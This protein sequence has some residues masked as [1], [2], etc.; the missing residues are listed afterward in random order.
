MTD[1]AE[2]YR[3]LEYIDA[4]V[5]AVEP[6]GTVF[7]SPF[8]ANT[9][10]RFSD[11]ELRVLL[12]DNDA[13]ASLGFSASVSEYDGAMLYTLSEQYE[14]TPGMTVIPTESI[15]RN[16]RQRETL[17]N[18]S[19]VCAYSDGTMDGVYYALSE[20]AHLLDAD[21]AALFV[22][23][24]ASGMWKSDCF[25]TSDGENSGYNVRFEIPTADFVPVERRLD[26]KSAS[27]LTGLPEASV[28]SGEDV[29]ACAAKV[30]T[31]NGSRAIL[32]LEKRGVN[33]AW[34]RG[35]VSFIY[36]IVGLLKMA[37]RRSRM[38]RELKCA[39]DDANAAS[40]AK[41]EFISR[42]S[43]EIRTPMNA[44]LGMIRLA[45]DSCS[46]DGDSPEYIRDCLRKAEGAGV[47]LLGIINDVLDF[48]LIE[49]GKMTLN[50]RSFMLSELLDRVHD[51]ITFAAADKDI[52]LSCECG[53]DVPACLYGDTQR[54]AQIMI[55]L[56]NNAV[57]FTESG[58]VR[59]RVSRRGD[60]LVIAVSD[61][62]SGIR[63]EDIGRLFRSFE[64]VNEES[65]RKIEGTGLGL[66]ITKEIIGHMGGEISVESVFGE[67]S[68]FTV[69][70]PLE[71]GR[72][73]E[74][75]AE[76]TDSDFYSP[77]SRLLVA[78]DNEVNLAVTVAV[79][80]KFGIDADT[81]SDGREA[82]RKAAEREYDLILMDH[83]MPVM[84]GD[85][86]CA[87]I[88]S[89]GPNAETPILALTANTALSVRRQL[90][91]SGMNDVV[92]KPFTPNQLSSVLEKYLSRQQAEIKEEQPDAPETASIPGV[93]VEE[94]AERMGCGMEFYR[95]ALRLTAAAIPDSIAAQR[96]QLSSGEL[97]ALRVEA[98]GIKGALNTIGAYQAAQ[99]ALAVEQAAAAEDAALAAAKLAEFS[100]DAETLYENLNI[101]L[102]R[103]AG[104]I[105]EEKKESDA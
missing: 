70:L 25:W 81:A 76:R 20:T 85:A 28:V 58:S 14:T 17:I 80:K 84:D 56:M 36:V 104:E 44:V 89:G 95:E 5:V 105:N 4:P 32:W 103:F 15:A 50:P 94:A 77:D 19:L 8:A 55:N 11:A 18:I 79:L 91:A 59:L 83:M 98:H 21:C 48:S 102:N 46:E 57:K 66:K 86:A 47:H 33:E 60:R 61:T 30:D 2:K 43:H 73:S 31:E 82:V 65:T 53:G 67:G 63:A 29:S 12:G 22:A 78:D 40:V 97:H 23:D 7:R 41:S 3:I 88:R 75:H 13:L 90:L 26:E 24:D 87:E 68:T 74:V 1:S 96:K 37:L 49:A 27:I 101:Y 6:D 52:R 45:E 100:A 38:E 99:L 51:I 69:T 10:H 64:R 71:L 34:A 72:E 93:E 16:A 62:G 92:T 35:D 39:L 54:L 9:L 42:I